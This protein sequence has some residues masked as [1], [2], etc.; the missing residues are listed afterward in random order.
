MPVLKP[1]PLDRVNI[2]VRD[3]Q[4]SMDFYTGFLGLDELS[5]S[6]DEDGDPDFV[7]LTA[8]RQI[9]YLSP[10]RDFRSPE[11]VADRGLNH[12][13]IVVEP[14]ELDALLQKLRD[15]GIPIR[16]EAA[17]RRDERG[18]SISTYVDD[19]DGHGVEIKQYPN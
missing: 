12:I 6:R 1:E 11:N 7:G 16:E 3:M 4:A 13:C 9:V 15:Q 2:K 8:G 10:N 19:P 14:L 5:V 17:R 18:A